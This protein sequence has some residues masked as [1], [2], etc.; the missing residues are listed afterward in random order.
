MIEAAV[1]L[2]FQESD[3]RV[4]VIALGIRRGMTDG[5]THGNYTVMT[6]A[7]FSKNLRVIHEGDNGK[8]EV[9]VT[10]LTYIAG[11]NVIR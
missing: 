8:P 2:Q 4:A 6:L 7:A 9:A 11:R 1:R 10:G 3:G 5:F